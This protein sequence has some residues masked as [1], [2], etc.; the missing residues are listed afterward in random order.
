MALRI[1]LVTAVVAALSAC[2]PSRLEGYDSILCSGT[3]IY[4]QTGINLERREYGMFDFRS[5]FTD[6]STSDYH[7]MAAPLVISM[8][9]DRNTPLDQMWSI[10]G[11][12]FRHERVE[13]GFQ[14]VAV[15]PPNDLSPRSEI[16]TRFSED[17]DLIEVVDR[18]QGEGAEVTRVCH[19]RINLRD[20]F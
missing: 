7:C 9:K 20:L 16:T 18:H 6:C 11:V 19:G 15:T 3:T 13:S 8:P 17:G 5:G 1:A 4:E 2:V 10:D 12:E 14:I